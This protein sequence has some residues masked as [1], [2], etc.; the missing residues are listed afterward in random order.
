ML[1]PMRHSAQDWIGQ[2]PC[3]DCLYDAGA[4]C[5]MAGAAACPLIEAALAGCMPPGFM[6]VAGQLACSQFEPAFAEIEDALH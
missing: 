1:L 3:A 6:T 5:G 2:L 4:Q